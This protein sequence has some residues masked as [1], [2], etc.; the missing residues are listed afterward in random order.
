LKQFSRVNEMVGKVNVWEKGMETSP[1][2]GE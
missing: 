1:V 2:A